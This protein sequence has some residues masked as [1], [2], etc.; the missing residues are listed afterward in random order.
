[1]QNPSPQQYALWWLSYMDW[2]LT[3]HKGTLYVHCLATRAVSTAMH[4]P[5]HT[6]Q[7]K[8]VVLDNLLQVSFRSKQN[9]PSWSR[10]AVI[11]GCMTHYMAKRLWSLNIMRFLYE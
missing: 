2:K 9:S 11:Y 7:V 10:N 1:M 6:S 8:K 3:S 5:S 4:W